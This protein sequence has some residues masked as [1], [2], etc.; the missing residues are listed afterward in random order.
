MPLGIVLEL[1]DTDYNDDDNDDDDY[2]DDEL[3][4][5]GRAHTLLSL[6]TYL[7]CTCIQYNRSYSCRGNYR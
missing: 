5:C 2:D 1:L 7:D 4:V 3:M 6:H